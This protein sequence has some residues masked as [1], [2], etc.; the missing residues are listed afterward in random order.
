MP[1]DS[2]EQDLQDVMAEEKSRGTR[3]RAVDT[4]ARKRQ[5]QLEKDALRAIKSGDLHAYV[6]MLH[7]A[8]MK[9]DSPEYANALK[10]FHSFHGPR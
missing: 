10:I 3:R 8:G 6:R 1:S 4:A 5:L 2:K 7:E 9:D